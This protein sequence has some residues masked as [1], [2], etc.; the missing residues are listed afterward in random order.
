MP[1]DNF[2]ID[3]YELKRADHLKAGKKPGGGCT[4]LHQG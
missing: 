4:T 3:G 2:T 1:T